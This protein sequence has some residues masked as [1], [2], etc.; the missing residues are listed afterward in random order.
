MTEKEPQL[1]GSEAE[2]ILEDFGDIFDAEENE[3]IV[4]RK[5]S[6]TEFFTRLEDA[7]EQQ[8]QINL[9]AQLKILSYRGTLEEARRSEELG[10]VVKY[11]VINERIFDFSASEKRPA[12][13]IKHHNPLLKV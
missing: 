13:F 9:E 4:V 2:E 7:I 3:E 10:M 1:S 12:G 11:R 5:I 8:N 6:R